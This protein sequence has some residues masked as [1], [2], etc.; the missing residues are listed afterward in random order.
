MRQ[1]YRNNASEYSDFSEIMNSKMRSQREY[2]GE[3]DDYRI[4]NEKILN[5]KKFE[6]D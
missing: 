3:C 5:L 1:N 6:F 2:T 4:V